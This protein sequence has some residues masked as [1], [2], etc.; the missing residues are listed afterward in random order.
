MERLS[1]NPEKDWRMWAA[2][3]GRVEFPRH[4]ED[5]EGLS[6]ECRCAD[7]KEKIRLTSD[8]NEFAKPLPARTLPWRTQAVMDR[9]SWKSSVKMASNT[10]R[11]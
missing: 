9:K 5:K 4:S 3:G 8:A 6:D 2:A 1:R 10:D 7:T 11:R